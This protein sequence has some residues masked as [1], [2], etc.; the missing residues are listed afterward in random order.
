MKL[1]IDR[2]TWLRGEGGD[3]SALLREKDGKMCCL[4]FYALAC[5]M[6]KEDIVGRGGPRSVT[7]TTDTPLPEQMQ[8]L[9]C[10]P[11]EHS[12]DATALMVENDNHAKEE[13]IAELFAKHGVEVEFVN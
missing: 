10:G 1:T 5:G 9:M 12:G 3:A 4:G 6:E 13:R 11:A 2:P 8:W 7:M